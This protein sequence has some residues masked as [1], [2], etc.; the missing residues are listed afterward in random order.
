M[1]IVDDILADMARVLRPL[2]EAAIADAKDEAKLQA[3]AEFKAKLAAV[4]DNDKVAPRSE[5]VTS[6]KIAAA[7]S[8]LVREVR[9]SR[10]TSGTVKPTIARLLHDRPGGITMRQVTEE[11]GFKYNSVRGT[12][13]LL[14]KEGQAANRDEKWFAA[15]PEPAKTLSLQQMLE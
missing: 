6:P 13:W 3:A 15:E 8:S 9:K 4:F 14:K 11:T 10:A 1:T 2:L 12:L 7:P 5:P